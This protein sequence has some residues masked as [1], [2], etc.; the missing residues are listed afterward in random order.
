MFDLILLS[1][2]EA[3]SV[4]EAEEARFTAA[5]EEAGDWS[6]KTLPVKGSDVLALGVEHGPAVGE[7]LEQ[8][9]ACGSTAISNLIATRCW[10]N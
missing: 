10:K 1:W 8:A 4:G 9:E 6:S 3:E 2:A 7:I 5:L